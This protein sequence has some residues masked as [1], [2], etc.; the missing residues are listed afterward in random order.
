LAF[1]ASSTNWR[2]W[3]VPSDVRFLQWKEAEAATQSLLG[4]RATVWE[5]YR[6]Y[7]RILGAA[8]SDIDALKSVDI[9]RSE[10]TEENFDSVY[11]DPSV[12]TRRRCRAK[13]TARR[14]PSAA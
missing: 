5:R 7:K 6:H 1:S 9:A 13:R 14:R 8:D 4:S 12:A 2:T 11:A 3:I 10:L